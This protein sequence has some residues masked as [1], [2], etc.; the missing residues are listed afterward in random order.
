[1]NELHLCLGRGGDPLHV[2]SSPRL[3][4]LGLAGPL[5]REDLVHD[6]LQERQDMQSEA[7]VMRF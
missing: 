3:D 1:L 5:G 2:G 4:E 6:L 7:T